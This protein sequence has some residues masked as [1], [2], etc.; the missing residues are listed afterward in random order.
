[1]QPAAAGPRPPPA[2]PRVSRSAS[3]QRPPWRVR[4]RKGR[5]RRTASRGQARRWP[6]PPLGQPRRHRRN[7]LVAGRR[8]LDR[9][10]LDHPEGVEHDREILPVRL[11]RNVGIQAHQRHGQPDPARHLI[12]RQVPKTLITRPPSLDGRRSRAGTASQMRSPPGRASNRLHVGG[13]PK[14]DWS[15]ADASLVKI[16]RPMPSPSSVSESISRFPDLVRH[17]ALEE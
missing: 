11:G 14:G 16:Q 1:M 10:H 13:H 7:V 17:W 9:K 12:I 4:G 15:G 5:Y 8:T 6:A 2:S 3:R